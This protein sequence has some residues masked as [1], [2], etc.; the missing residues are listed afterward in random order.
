[1]ATRNYVG[2]TEQDPIPSHTPYVDGGETDTD[3][4]DDET[5]GHS[6][7]LGQMVPRLRPSTVASH[8]VSRICN[9]VVDSADRNL[10]SEPLYAFH[11][12]FAS[13][14]SEVGGCTVGRRLRDVTKIQCAQL[15]FPIA[16]EVF[17]TVHHAGALVP[18]LNTPRR[19]R[20]RLE[21]LSRSSDEIASTRADFE[22][23]YQV[24]AQDT[25][26]YQAKF[27]P[28]DGALNGF[29]APEHL[30]SLHVHLEPDAVQFQLLVREAVEAAR[31]P[32]AALA[33]PTLDLYPFAAL[34]YDRGTRTLKVTLTKSIDRRLVAPGYLFGFARL[35]F[36]AET[37]FE[38][39]LSAR[40]ARRD[41]RFVVVEV[42]SDPEADERITAITLQLEFTTREATAAHG[43]L[44]AA[45][46]SFLLDIDHLSNNVLLSHAMQY[47]LRLDIDYHARTLVTSHAAPEVVA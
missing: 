5:H 15:F 13:Q 2:L 22:D 29:A 28:F 42:E 32:R 35:S 46:H 4:D 30:Q 10:F 41:E 47:M 31:D 21:P 27:L 37:A 7:S 16:N 26:D 36:E 8:G 25:A 44:D 39:A 11:V 20:L 40:A 12:H 38:A 1:M 34:L 9:I 17:H 43:G 6:I 45:Q 14:R 3:G 23:A 18:V 33:L 19:L 24:M